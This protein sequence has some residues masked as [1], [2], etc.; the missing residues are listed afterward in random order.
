MP[1]LTPSLAHLYEVQ[2]SLAAGL[3]DKHCQVQVWL[4]HTVVQHPQ[5]H[6]GVVCSQDSINIAEDTLKCDICRADINEGLLIDTSA[7]MNKAEA[8][9]ERRA[10]CHMIAGVALPAMTMTIEQICYV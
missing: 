6:R 5:Q 3:H 8:K 7:M 10:A 4:P 2:S 1:G 9:D